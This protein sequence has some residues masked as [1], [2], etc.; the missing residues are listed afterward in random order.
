MAKFPKRLNNDI[1]I[2]VNVEYDPLNNWLCNLFIW[3]A[4]KII[5]LACYIFKCGI[6]IEVN[7]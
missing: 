6:K 2:K 5:H 4:S 3:I 7:Q 1:K